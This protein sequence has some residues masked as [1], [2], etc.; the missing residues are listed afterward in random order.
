[1]VIDR[2]LTQA[3]PAEPVNRQFLDNYVQN[4]YLSVQRQE[5]ALAISAAVAVMIACLGLVG[6]SASLA[7]RRTKEIGIRKAMGAHTADILRMLLW[8]FTRPVLASV[9]VAWLV[10]GVV[11]NRWLHGF[12]YH[13]ELD[14]RLMAGAAVAGLIIA[15]ATVSTHCYLIARARPVAALRYE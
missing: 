15:L 1:L 10:A 13:V 7:Q 8:Q 9:S 5:Q 4:L 14:V 12:A 11:M 6:L 3:N 2:L